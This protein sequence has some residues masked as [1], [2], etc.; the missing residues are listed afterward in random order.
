MMYADQSSNLVMSLEEWIYD[1]ERDEAAMLKR[2]RETNLRA[3]GV[4]NH[5][6]SR[7][8]AMADFDKKETVTLDKIIDKK[9]KLRE[10]RVIVAGKPF[11]INIMDL[12][13]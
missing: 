1:L 10:K 12:E 7:A 13:M 11:K 5:L 2:L 6:M 4:E 3:E 8:S 9:R